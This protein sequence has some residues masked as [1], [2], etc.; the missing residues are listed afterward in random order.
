MKTT[1]SLPLAA[2]LGLLALA[3]TVQAAP[4]KLAG[5]AVSPSGAATVKVT[6]PNRYTL[7]GTVALA[8]GKTKLGSRKVSV[9]GK[10]SKKVSLKLSKA[11]LAALKGK[12]SLATTLTARLA[13]KGHRAKSYRKALVLRRRWSPGSTRR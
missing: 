4:A 9:K 5:G 11:G 13:R 7:K 3:P 12:G 1:T 8:S 2:A 6:N 10:R